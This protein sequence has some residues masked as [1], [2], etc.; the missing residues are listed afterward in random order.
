MVRPDGAYYQWRKDPPRE[1]SKDLV[2]N[3]RLDEQ[4]DGSKPR[5]K[6]R[7]WRPSNPAGHNVSEA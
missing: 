3:E 1:L 4:S 6:D 5:D 2:A 7:F